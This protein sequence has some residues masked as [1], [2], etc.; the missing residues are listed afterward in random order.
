MSHKSLKNSFTEFPACELQ[1]YWCCPGK[2]GF[3]GTLGFTQPCVG[4]TS[5]LVHVPVDKE[6]KVSYKYSKIY[7]LPERSPGVLHY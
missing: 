7:Y 4:E 2:V 6:V 3:F 1:F 5:M